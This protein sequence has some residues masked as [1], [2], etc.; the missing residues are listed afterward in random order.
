MEKVIKAR[1]KEGATIGHNMTSF[2]WP[3]C[4]MSITLGQTTENIKDTI[5]ECSLVH[6]S[7]Y[8]NCVASGFGE[9][10]NNVYGNGSVIVSKKEDLIIVQETDKSII[11]DSENEV[12]TYS[13][14]IGTKVIHAFPRPANKD[15][16]RGNYPIGSPGYQV[17]YKDD[18]TSWSPKKEFEDAYEL[19]ENLNFG[20]ALE[21]LKKGYKVGNTLWDKNIDGQPYKLYMKIVTLLIDEKSDL[22]EFVVY[23][24]LNNDI[25]TSNAI[26]TWS[27]DMRY[28]LSNSWYILDDELQLR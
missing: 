21:A 18:Y 13:K 15:D 5:F 28:M 1:I 11:N 27:C 24:Y 6:G 22:D 26:G 3:K 7:K 9:I 25:A 12:I 10:G 2:I 23:E 14:Y 19:T 17:K 4:K 20:L 8:Y 16:K